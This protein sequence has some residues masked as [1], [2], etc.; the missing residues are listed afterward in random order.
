MAA[1]VQFVPTQRWRV[2]CRE[3]AMTLGFEESEVWGH[4]QLLAWMHERETGYDRVCAEILAYAHVRAVFDKRGEG[5]P[6]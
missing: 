3:L 4:F 6:S 2:A 1:P 5:M